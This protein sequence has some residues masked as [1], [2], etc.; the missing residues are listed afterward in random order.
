MV[1]VRTIVKHA[2]HS[3]LVT[4]TEPRARVDLLTFRCVIN[5]DVAERPCHQAMRRRRRSLLELQCGRCIRPRLC[6][7]RGRSRRCRLFRYGPFI[8][9]RSCAW[10]LRCSSR[11]RGGFNGRRGGTATGSARLCGPGSRLRAG[12]V[13]GLHRER[14]HKQI[15]HGERRRLDFDDVA[16]RRWLRPRRF[17]RLNKRN[18]CEHFGCC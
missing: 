17:C 3:L 4:L 2:K 6:C 1:A 8:R 10:P 9:R 14:R 11:D 15:L 18:R 16:G 12:F 13:F 5:H 7:R